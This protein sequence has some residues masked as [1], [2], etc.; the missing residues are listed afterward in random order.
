MQHYNFKLNNNF[1]I[2]VFCILS[3][4]AY[5]VLLHNNN[6]EYYISQDKITVVKKSGWLNK[7]GDEYKVIV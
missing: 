2:F 5:Q 1:I 4:F 7:K 6:I 3:F